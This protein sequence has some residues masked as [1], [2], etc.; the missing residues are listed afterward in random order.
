MSDAPTFNKEESAR[1]LAVQI[2]AKALSGHQK[3]DARLVVDF[4]DRLLRYI[5]EGQ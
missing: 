3:L 5:K 1:F 4:A 2:A